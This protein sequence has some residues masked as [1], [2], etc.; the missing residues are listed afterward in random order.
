MDPLAGSPWSTPET[1][2]G[3]V[4]SPPKDVLLNAAARAFALAADGRLL[5]IGCGAGRNAVPLAEAGWRVLGT[6]L[7]RPMLAAARDRVSDPGA[8]GRLQLALA[9]MDDLPVASGSID[10]VVAHGSRGR[11]GRGGSVRLHPVLRPAAMLPD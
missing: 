1:V 10:F 5:D 11:A 6:D 9:P 3:F 8:G 2:A 4:R 7:S